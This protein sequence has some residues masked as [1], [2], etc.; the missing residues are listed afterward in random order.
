MLGMGQAALDVG[1]PQALVEIDA[2]GVALH[3]LAHRLGEQGRPRLGFLVELVAGHGRIFCVGSAWMEAGHRV[4]QC[5][6]II[7]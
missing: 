7:G 3:Q 4:A 6:R 2:G 1:A 5:A